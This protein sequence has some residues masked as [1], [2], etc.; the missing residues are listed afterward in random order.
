MSARSLLLSGLFVCVTPLGATTITIVNLD[1]GGE[2]FNDGTVVSALPGNP[3]TTRG[4]QR[5]NVF[6]AAADYWERVLSS[7]VEII[8]NASMDPND[9][10]TAG[11]GVLGSASAAGSV[12]DDDPEPELP[13]QSTWY[14]LA[15]ASSIV[16]EDVVPG[17][18][19]IAATFNTRVDGDPTCFTSSEWWYGIGAAAPGGTLDFY[20]T[21]VHE[22]GHGLGFFTLVNK[23]TGVKLSGFNDAYMIHLEDHSTGETWGSPGMSD[24][25]R[26]ASGKDTGDLHWIGTNAIA[27]ADAPVTAGQ[28]AGGHLQMFAPDPVQ[29]GSSISHWDTALIPNETME[30]GLTSDARIYLTH[31]L[32]ADIGWTVL[33][34]FADTFESANSSFWSS[35]SP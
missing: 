29:G 15:L 22:I 3:A 34:I 24:A 26:A 32:M 17:V 8:V 13:L 9:N 7:A 31:G 5:L 10:C 20:T 27:L 6:L 30:P 4:G 19:D 1:G 12:R 35:A 33:L 28:H 21:V 14:N 25:E 16:G 23:T 11:G 18:H 2:G